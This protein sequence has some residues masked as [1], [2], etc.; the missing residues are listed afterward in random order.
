MDLMKYTERMRA[1]REREGYFPVFRQTQRR[2]QGNWEPEPEL[3]QPTW[4][5][6]MPRSRR[7]PW[8]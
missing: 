3:E 1:F 5:R 6:F 8:K 4:P 7:R 2:E